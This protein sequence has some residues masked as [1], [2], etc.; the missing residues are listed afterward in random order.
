MFY[1]RND[2]GYREI[3]KGV[4]IKTLV[5]GEKT[6]FAEF[7]LK[8]GHG[9]PRHAHPYEQTGYLVSGSIELSIGEETFRVEPGDCWC[10]PE[11]VEHHAEILSDSVA[12]DVF[13]PPRKDYMPEPKA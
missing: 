13:S 3:V 1:K 9:L 5:Y 8:A 4:A 11:N 12:I 7:H 10:I 6:L 2:S